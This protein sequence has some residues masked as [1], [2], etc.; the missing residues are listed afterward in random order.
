MIC[1]HVEIKIFDSRGVFVKTI[2][3]VLAIY[4]YKNTFGYN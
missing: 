4:N 1:K 3:V 2:A